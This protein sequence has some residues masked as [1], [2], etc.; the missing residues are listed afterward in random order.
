VLLLFSDWRE[1]RLAGLCTLIHWVIIFPSGCDM[2]LTVPIQTGNDH[3]HSCT[4]CHSLK[5]ITKINEE[6]ENQKKN[7]E[8]QRAHRKQN[9]ADDFEF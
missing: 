3:C 7:S 6:K 1:I 2:N 5:I 4:T 9:K 8:Q